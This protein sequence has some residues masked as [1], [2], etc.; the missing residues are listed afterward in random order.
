MIT[1]YDFLVSLRMAEAQQAAARERLARRLRPSVG[2]L[3]F[4]S[5]LIGRPAGPGDEYDLAA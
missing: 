5:R 1:H 4:V 3:G 2:F